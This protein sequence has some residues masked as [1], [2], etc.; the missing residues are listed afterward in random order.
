MK[1]FISKNKGEIIAV[2]MVL[3]II[4]LGFGLDFEQS[5]TLWKPKL[6]PWFLV[7]G[8]ALF[9][10]GLGWLAGSTNRKG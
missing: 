5:Q 3:G 2:M 7:I 9:F 4:L 8:P 10:G 1:K 6:A